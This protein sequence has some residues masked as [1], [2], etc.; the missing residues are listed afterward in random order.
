MIGKIYLGLILVF[1]ILAFA[2]RNIKTYVSTK[3]SIRGKSLKLTVSIVTS[4]LI[5]V[6]ILLRLTV[7]SGNWIL[8]LNFGIVD[9]LVYVGY[10]F[11]TLGFGIG[12]LALIVMK[13]SWRVGIKYDQKTDLVS[14]GIYRYSRNPYFLSYSILIFGYI[15]IF[16]S[17]ILFGLLF[18]LAIV[19][20]KMIL[21]EEKYLETVHGTKYL[22]YK[23]K[24]NR[25]ITFK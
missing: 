18:L 9:K 11:V 15:L 17:I 14:S 25:Y 1:F 3:N 22:D 24:V 20:H 21:E 4:T 23:K 8:E 19:F 13:N 7:L 2:V 6:L 10:V 5:Y 12:V 16:P